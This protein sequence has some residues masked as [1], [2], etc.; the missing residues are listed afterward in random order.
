MDGDAAPAADDGVE[1]LLSAVAPS[2]PPVDG[3]AGRFFMGP[4]CS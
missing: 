3:A 2:A 1:V 4:A